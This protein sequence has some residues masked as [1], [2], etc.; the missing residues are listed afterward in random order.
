V[1]KV[2]QIGQRFTVTTRVLGWDHRAIYLEHV[3]KRANT[4]IDSALIDAQFLSR[5]GCKVT[6]AELLELTGI[7]EASPPLPEHVQLWIRANQSDG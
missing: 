7:C 2:A 5:A 3:F 6:A 4:V 1:Q